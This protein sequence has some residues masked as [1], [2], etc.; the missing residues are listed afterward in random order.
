[1]E[2]DHPK[3]VKKHKI[4]I[5]PY[6][7]GYGYV[8]IFYDKKG[9]V[10]YVG[11]SKNLFS[12]LTCQK[13]HMNSKKM[14]VLRV[15]IENLWDV[16][17]FYTFKL[18]PYENKISYQNFE[19]VPKLHFS[20][21]TMSL[22]EYIEKFDIDVRE[23]AKKVGTDKD[24]IKAHTSK[25]Y[26]LSLD[27]AINIEQITNGVVPREQILKDNPIKTNV[28]KRFVSEGLIKE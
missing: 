21:I 7:A 20:N 23:F 22:E 24:K 14:V 27:V 12:R 18:K 19:H 10:S 5:P 9:K 3:V 28:Y 11:Q 13:R 15:K 4:I 17:R 6:R 8:Y 1:M 25:R 16:E 2:F 26:N